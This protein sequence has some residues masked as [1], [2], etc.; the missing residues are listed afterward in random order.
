[1]WPL[2]CFVQTTKT[3]CRT[4]LV[5][6][7][8]DMKHKHH[9]KNIGRLPTCIVLRILGNLKSTKS[10]FLDRFWFAYPSSNGMQV[11]MKNTRTLSLKGCATYT[12]FYSF[13]NQCFHFHITQFSSHNVHRTCVWSELCKSTLKILSTKIFYKQKR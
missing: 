8:E 9:S 4:W 12:S 13:P 7:D 5:S 11:L 6:W 10:I 2:S 3:A 1:M